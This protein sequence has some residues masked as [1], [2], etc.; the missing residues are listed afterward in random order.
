MT[1][2]KQRKKG[3]EVES[4]EDEEGV[5]V[6]GESRGLPGELPPADS[7]EGESSEDDDLVCKSITDNWCLGALT[8]VL[9]S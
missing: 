4:E 7:S 8:M 9:H 2:S 3:I 1:P 6:G 5:A